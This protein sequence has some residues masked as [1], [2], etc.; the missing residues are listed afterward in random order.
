MQPIHILFGTESGNA[1]GLAKRAV[2]LVRKAGF[3][4]V[5]VDMTDFDPSSIQDVSTALV[6]TSTFGNGDPPFNAEKLHAY[7]MKECPELPLLRFS[8]LALGDTTYDHFAQC[9]KD[10]DRRLGELK[11]QRFAPR[12]DC[13][14]DYEEPF[15]S[16][17]ETVLAGL[18]KLDF[19]KAPPAPPSTPR[20]ESEEPLGSRRRPLTAAVR[21]NER[22]TGE[23]ST[24][25]ARHLVLGWEAD[26]FAYELGDSVGIWP[27]HGEALVESI[28][29]AVGLDGA[30]TVVV[31]GV[32]VALA[33]ALRTKLDIVQVDAR[34]IAKLGLATDAK[35]TSK[36][37]ETH[38]VVDL[39]GKQMAALSA[40]DL[41]DSLRP[42]S[43]RLYSIASSPVVHPKEVYLL[44][45]VI[46]Y[47]LHGSPRAGVFS[48][49]AAERLAL[50]DALPIYRHPAPHFRL[51]ES[52]RPIVMIGPGTGV[53]P[54]RGFVEER[55]VTGATASSWL[56]FGARNRAT[57]FFYE[58]ELSA[59]EKAGKVRLSLAF[60]RDQ[61]DKEYVWHLMRAHGKELHR[62]MA[63]G[64][65]VYVCGSAKR[66]APDVHRTLIEIWMVEGGLD[67]DRATEQ[68][69]L[70]ERERR[71]QRDVY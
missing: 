39:L 16:W 63:E 11:A 31:G 30:T 21:E 64:A 52:D 14:V 58:P 4:A 44:V 67:R 38:H 34:L 5:V 35:Q 49:Q 19:G 20:L 9:G 45:D 55:V 3:E 43:P 54:F 70:M 26:G 27:T 60:S 6:I 65:V 69:A 48:E 50:G 57:D 29:K 33:D 32:K 2:E 18:S 1:E 40:Q 25:E 13:D 56:F 23:A 61:K 41:V 10:F 15:Q 53:A 8:V 46:R 66:M 62:Q 12:V 59:W 37:I 51:C 36:L 22:A 68:L 42:L 71:Y 24:K 28:L 17:L 47:A 7:L